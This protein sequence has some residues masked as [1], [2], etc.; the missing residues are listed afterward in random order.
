MLQAPHPTAGATKPIVVERVAHRPAV[1]KA[2]PPPRSAPLR[3]ACPNCSGSVVRAHRRFVDV[4]LGAFILLE[5]RRYRCRHCG[6]RGNLKRL[7]VAGR[8]VHGTDSRYHGQ[9]RI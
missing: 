2:P 6:W 3:Y 5:L 9:C 1:P 8:Q 4:I 7:P